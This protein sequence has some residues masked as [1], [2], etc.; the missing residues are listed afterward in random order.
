MKS[1]NAAVRTT[2]TSI[3][4]ASIA[5]K[6]CRNEGPAQHIQSHTDSHRPGPQE[7]TLAGGGP[8]RS[9]SNTD[10][11][12]RRRRV[13][14]Y[15]PNDSYRPSLTCTNDQSGKI[16]QPCKK[17]A[18]F[19]SQTTKERLD[20]RLSPWED[21]QLPAKKRHREDYLAD[22]G[23]PWDDIHKPLKRQ[24]DYPSDS[25]SER[26]CLSRKSNSIESPDLEHL[27][28]SQ[29]DNMEMNKVLD[30]ELE[31]AGIMADAFLAKLE[32]E[33]AQESDFQGVGASIHTG[34]IEDSENPVTSLKSSTTQ[35]RSLVAPAPSNDGGVCMAETP[36]DVYASV[37]N[38][39][40]IDSASRGPVIVS[41]QTLKPLQRDPPYDR[42]VL[43]LFRGREHEN[44]YVNVLRRR[45]A[46]DMY[47]ETDE[48]RTATEL[49]NLTV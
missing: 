48:E 39:G 6:D 38:L 20:G 5:K 13:D 47:E 44:V 14:S 46:I 15:R 17:E 3:E 2:E 9:G 27:R 32:R 34:I 22:E 12:G 37:S 18:K 40:S 21:M 11:I 28:T 31:V 23:L 19:Y 33:L 7:L 49:S 4:Q 42:C 35:R 41:F 29:K 36:K 43:D 30:E 16:E 10:P 1:Q 24:R 45:T 26:I 25:P 8:L